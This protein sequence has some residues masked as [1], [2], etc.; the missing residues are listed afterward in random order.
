MEKTINKEKM[1]KVQLWEMLLLSSVVLFFAD[2]F[3]LF[4]AFFITIPLAAAS[5]IIATIYAVKE[6]K[7]VYVPA[8]ILLVLLPI[9]ALLMLPW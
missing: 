6:R 8:N 2:T 4:G 7:Y 9:A 1:S 5:G 3:I